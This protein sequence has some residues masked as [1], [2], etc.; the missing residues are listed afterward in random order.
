MPNSIEKE[1]VK[2][3]MDVIRP[4]V[5]A[6]ILMH[7]KK[8]KKGFEDVHAKVA[9]MK[10]STGGFVSTTFLASRNISKKDLS[11]RSLLKM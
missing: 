7:A 10:K 1:K 4:E 3:A 6:A 9:F 2:P 8:K 11:R 5:T